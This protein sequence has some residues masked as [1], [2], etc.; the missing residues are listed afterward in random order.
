M[1]IRHIY[2]TIISLIVLVACES[3]PSTPTTTIF[4]SLPIASPVERPPNIPTPIPTDT[5]K[6]T[7]TPTPIATPTIILPI[8]PASAND[9]PAL[10]HDLLFINNDGLQH[11]NHLTQ[12]IERLVGPDDTHNAPTG[13]SLGADGRRLAFA[14]RTSFH[15][16]EIALLDVRTRQLTTLA[17][18]LSD[19]ENDPTRLFSMAISPDGKWVGYMRQGTLPIISSAQWRA[20]GQPPEP[21]FIQAP[22]GEPPAGMIFAVRADAPD[23][24]LEIGYCAAERIAGGRPRGCQGILWG[25]DSRSI[26]WSDGRG[27]W[28]SE[29]GYA[30]ASQVA[31]NAITP[32]SQL[33]AGL[34]RLIA[35]S[36]RGRYLLGSVEHDEGSN[37]GVLDTRFHLSAGMTNTLRLIAPR[38]Q[39]AWMPDG[40]LFVVKPGNQRNNSPPSGEIWQVETGRTASLNLE[41]RLI[42]VAVFVIDVDAENIATVPAALADGRL[43]F[44]LLNT[45]AT[46]YVDRGLYAVDVSD[47]TPRKLNGLPPARDDNFKVRIVWTSDGAG[48][49]VQGLTVGPLYVPADGHSPYDLAP[50]VGDSACCFTWV[51]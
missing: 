17:L 31:P 21:T 15:Q 40:R 45:S 35:W 18:F 37:L 33:E 3:V 14:R 48:A 42:R 49:I 7:M 28:V 44:A 10:T 22:D 27:V 50:L 13:F 4:V 30:S 47:L 11:W 36:P 24:R 39:A 23:R 12:K 41:L 51:P 2:M 43:V 9:L 19:D 26:A 5:P 20:Q 46:N 29:L 25:P 38:P 34:W 8:R 6:P 16:D 32:R 1:N